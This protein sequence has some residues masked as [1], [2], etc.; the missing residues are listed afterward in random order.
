MATAITPTTTFTAAEDY[1]Q[2]YHFT[3]PIRYKFYKW[4]CGRAQ[5]LE[6]IWGQSLVMSQPNP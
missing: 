3:N 4:N 1:H 6:E 2:N 5:R